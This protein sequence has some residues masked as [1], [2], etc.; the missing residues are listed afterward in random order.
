MSHVTSAAN[1]PFI[2]MLDP[3]FVLAAM[4]KSESLAQLN[5]HTCRPLDRIIP[6]PGS[7]DGEAAEAANDDAVEGAQAAALQQHSA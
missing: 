2:L 4:E 6:T 1:N 7:A 3:E 5:R